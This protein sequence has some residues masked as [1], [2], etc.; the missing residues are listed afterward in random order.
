MS[1]YF[2]HYS[3]QILVFEHFYRF[4]LQ[5]S[6]THQSSCNVV[7][8]W[9]T[10]LLQHEI[11]YHIE[12]VLE[13]KCQKERCRTRQKVLTVN[14]WVLKWPVPPNLIRAKLLNVL[15]LVWVNHHLRQ[16]HPKSPKTSPPAYNEVMRE[17]NEST[18][19]PPHVPV[20][21]V[22]RSLPPVSCVTKCYTTHRCSKWSKYINWTFCQ[23]YRCPSGFQ[24]QQWCRHVHP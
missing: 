16:L 21:L 17:C 8:D 5:M 22:L 11:I 24:L 15:L 14:L 3:I 13:Y 18:E 19:Q 2:P 20:V 1:T 23:C 7:L 6:L 10:F 9:S 12:P 4:M